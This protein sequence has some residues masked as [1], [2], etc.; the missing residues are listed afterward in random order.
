MAPCWA[1]VLVFVLCLPQF[2]YLWPGGR[3]LFLS[4]NKRA[5]A[6]ETLGFPAIGVA[7]L[8]FHSSYMLN[9]VSSLV[10]GLLLDKSASSFETT[11]CV[12]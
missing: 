4:R 3:R 7:V 2:F 11:E 5:R 12:D 10:V 6:F 1:F 8:L 9:G